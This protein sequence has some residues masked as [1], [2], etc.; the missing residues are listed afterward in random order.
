MIGQKLL[1]RLVGTLTCVA[2]VTTGWDAEAARCHRRRACCSTPC[3]YDTCC[4]T[5]VCAG[6]C[7]APACTTSCAPVYEQVCWTH[8]DPCTNCCVRT[9]GYRVVDSTCCVA[10]APACCAEVVVASSEG[11]PTVAGTATP[12]ATSVAVRR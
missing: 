9:C 12:A 4:S 2:A 1:I 8:R 3:C 7:C 11:A 5:N 10:T 6:S